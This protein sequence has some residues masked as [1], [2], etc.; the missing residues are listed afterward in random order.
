MAARLACQRSLQTAATAAGLNDLAHLHIAKGPLAVYRRKVAAGQLR[1]DPFQQNTMQV[2]Q[3]LHDTLIAYQP[4]PIVNV[5][6]KTSSGS[7]HKVGLEQLDSE[8]TS[9]F[10]LFS[11]KWWQSSAEKPVKEIFGPQGLYVYG[12]VGTGKTMTMDM[13]YH[14][15]DVE[16]KRRVHFHAFMLDVHRRVHQLRKELSAGFDPIPPVAQELANQ[17][18]LLCFDEL[19]VTD[20]TD[21][22]LLRRLFYELFKRGVVVF[23]TSNRPPDDLYK[24]GI[25]RSSFLPTIDLLKGR[26]LIHSLDSG[27]DYRVTGRRQ[28]SAFYHPLDKSTVDKVEAVWQ[29]LTQG[30]EV[31]P[32][33]LDFFGRSLVLPETVGPIVR[34]DFQA[35]C[36]QPHSAPDFLT[37]AQEFKVLILTNVPKLSFAQ[38]NEARR[39]IT[40]IDA[41]YENR[42]KLIISAEAPAD[43]LLVGEDAIPNASDVSDAHRMLMDDLKLSTKEMDSS[44]F[45]GAEE[46]FAFRRAV[47]RLYEMQ[48]YDWLGEDL[49]TALNKI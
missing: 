40:L 48:S 13:F 41:L 46:N 5:D 35:L 8:A 7:S 10:S 9:M 44:I 1:D 17:A 12:S 33:K 11:R 26:C 28:S 42:V 16:R 21:A 27:V 22:M 23:T 39:F 32:R 14:S 34:A 49:A 2:L 37:M 45:T 20:I 30:Q 3:R 25:Q 36:G 19:Q 24:N 6:V 4:P 38:R 15:I 29:H 43:Q 31:K 18:W 47:S